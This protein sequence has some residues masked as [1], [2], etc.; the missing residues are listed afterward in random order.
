MDNEITHSFWCICYTIL[1]YAAQYF[2]AQSSRTEMNKCFVFL[3]SLII[4]IF[5]QKGHAHFWPH[6]FDFFFFVTLPGFHHF[7]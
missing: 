2:S 3:D 1:Q 6:H 4:D 7:A 5:F